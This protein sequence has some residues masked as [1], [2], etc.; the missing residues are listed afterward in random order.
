MA[1]TKIL[2]RRD[3]ETNFISANPV[4]ELGEAA[5]LTDS[6]RMKIGN[7]SDAWADLEYFTPADDD[8]FYNLTAETTND[9]LDLILVFDISASA[10]RKMTRAD[11]LKTDSIEIDGIQVVGAQQSAIADV[12]DL[13]SPTAGTGSGA[14]ATTFSGSECDALRAEVLDLKT[15]LNSVL[16]MLRT[17][18]LI[19]S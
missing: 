16:A 10:Y 18:G 3:T 15:Q 14:D 11:F 9:D 1:I 4:L 6:G 5:Y 12:A 7:G 17:H 8:E 13:T 2:L 19:S